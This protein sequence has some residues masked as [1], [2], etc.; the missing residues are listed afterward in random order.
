MTEDLRGRLIAP[1]PPARII[2]SMPDQPPTLVRLSKIEALNEFLDEGRTMIYVNA[3]AEEVDVPQPFKDNPNLR[4]DL[5][6]RFPRPMAVTEAGVMAELSFGGTPH[7]CTIPWDAIFGMFNHVTHKEL[8]WPEDI[9]VELLEASLPP[10]TTPPKAKEK[11]RA[12]PKL[13]AVPD[14]EPLPPT[15][16]PGQD[17]QPEPPDDGPPKRPHLRLV[18]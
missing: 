3:R 7:T 16:T 13:V 8:L 14:P 15:I 2:R 12:R 9:P 1:R 10:A 17:E 18:K 6:R 4:L 5:S 11:A